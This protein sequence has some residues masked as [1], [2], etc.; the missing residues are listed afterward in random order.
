MK[1]QE[2]PEKYRY[3]NEIASLPFSKELC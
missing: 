2:T 3:R 1:N